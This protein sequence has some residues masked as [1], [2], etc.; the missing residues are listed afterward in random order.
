MQQV[1]LC[2]LLFLKAN[3]RNYGDRL[4]NMEK[5][6]KEIME[7]M[8]LCRNTLQSVMEARVDKTSL[9]YLKIA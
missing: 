3:N 7:I 2:V 9:L 1:G 4:D 8:Y 6:S 5:Q